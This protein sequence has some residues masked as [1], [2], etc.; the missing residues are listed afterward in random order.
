[1]RLFKCQTC[2]QILHFE[3]TG[4]ERCGARLGYDPDINELLTLTADGDDWVPVADST[5]R[6]RF[7]AN[8][9]WDACNWVV[10]ADGED[11]FCKACQ[12][13]CTVPDPTNP[14]HLLLWQLLEYAKHAL[15][16]AILRFG[17]PLQRRADADS[18]GL[19]F[20]FLADPPAAEGPRVITGYDNGLITIA[21]IEADDAQ[22]E[23]RR[24]AMKETYRTLL[25]HVRHE[26]GHHYWVSLVRDAGHLDSFRTTFG[27][28][29]PDYNT[30]L[31]NYYANA[32]PAD[33]QQC[34][35][36][37][38]ATSHPWEDF[39]ETWAHYLHMVDTLEVAHA[40]GLRTRPILAEDDLLNTEV[41]FDPY[42]V[43]DTEQLVRVWL[44]L[45]YVANSLNR[46]IGQPDL[47]P[48]ILSPMVVG[49]LAFIGRIIHGEKM[50][51]ND[52]S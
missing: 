32:P 31:Q 38:Y 2:A 43:T 15:F 16:Y 27:D 49:K 21:L 45:S 8:A 4:C 3:N 41:L 29:Q 23:A 19:A 52:Q 30:A 26:V 47:Y 1:M 20:D 22:R 44:P 37:A 7:C 25:G 40:F 46:A 24:T 17:L 50:A 39:A 12:H 35:I 5:R 11:D 33:W 36:S 13:N 10:A 34:F 42:S 18:N 14:E 48:F 9:E 6:L 51:P 28:E